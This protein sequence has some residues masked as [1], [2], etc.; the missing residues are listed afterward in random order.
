MKFLTVLAISIGLLTASQAMDQPSFHTK[1]TPTGKP[2][3]ALKPGQYW[4]H[5]EIS[6]EGPLMILVSVPE[7]MMHVYRNGILIGRSTVSTGSKGH[8]TPGGVFTILEKKQSHRSKKYNNAPMPNMQRLTWT[9][10]AMHS[11]QLPGYAA[12]H[13]C[14]RLPYDFS[15]LLFQATVNG[16]T[17]VVGDGKTPTPHLASNPG[18]LLAPKDFTPEMVRQLATDEYDWKPERSMQGPI[19]IVLSSAD[20]AL[21]VYRNGNPIGRAAVQVSGRG[22]LGNQVFTLLEGSTGKP[23]QLAPGHEA[24]KWMRVT[25]QGRP[26][27]ADDITSRIRFNTDFAQKLADEIKPG[28]TVIVTD[29]PVVRNP[30]ADSTYFAAK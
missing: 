20:R 10:I 16:G 26:V 7:Q 15:Q 2:T 5:P 25:S 3:G 21:Y 22:G 28:T 29:Q 12:S 30:I 18:L 23:S 6:P 8:E 11:G 19:T 1:G 27:E 24:R 17:V 13:G 9:G 4:W 14:I